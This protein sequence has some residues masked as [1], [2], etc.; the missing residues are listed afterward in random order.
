MK[1]LLKNN[2]QAKA[3]EKN[4]DED[5]EQTEDD[6]DSGNDNN[7]ADD[8]NNNDPVV[9]GGNPSTGNSYGEGIFLPVNGDKINI[10]TD[11]YINFFA[12]FHPKLKDLF[13]A[14]CSGASGNILFL[15]AFF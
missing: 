15:I 12:Q 9:G 10:C 4:K 6:S 8:D 2:N 3:N 13:I 1:R 5:G 11:E 7:Q 14:T